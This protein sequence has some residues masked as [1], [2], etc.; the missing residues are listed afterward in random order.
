MAK[1]I[2]TCRICKA[3]MT[4]LGTGDLWKCTKNPTHV[5]RNR[6]AKIDVDAKEPTFSE[7]YELAS[8]T[9]DGHKADEVFPGPVHAREVED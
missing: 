2:R 7:D 3:K 8:D 1:L 6:P 9:N 4:R 5:F